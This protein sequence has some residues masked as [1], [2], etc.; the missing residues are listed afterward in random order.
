MELGVD[1]GINF[2]TKNGIWMGSD[3]GNKLGVKIAYF[4]SLPFFAFCDVL[5]SHAYLCLQIP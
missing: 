3:D 1:D 4:V 2:I 5:F